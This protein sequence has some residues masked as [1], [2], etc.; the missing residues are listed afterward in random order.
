MEIQ[1][2]QTYYELL[3]WI[4]ICSLSS[5]PCQSEQVW[6]ANSP[7]GTGS[8]P[9]DLLWATR[10]SCQLSCPIQA[11]ALIPR[12]SGRKPRSNNTLRALFFIHLVYSIAHI[13]LS[14]PIPIR[15]GLI[16]GVSSTV[17]RS[18]GRAG[19]QS[20][21]DSSLPRRSPT[22]SQT[23]RPSPVSAPAIPEGKKRTN[24]T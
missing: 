7:T 2:Y 19:P 4:V 10:S 11:H 9:G 18:E 16:P 1:I 12:R 24:R 20:P 17:P 14:N 15:G 3:N 6:C 13:S 21:S 23:D 5:L 8:Q 22:V